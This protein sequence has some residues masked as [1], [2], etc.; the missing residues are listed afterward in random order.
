MD[1]LRTTK[2]AAEALGVD[3]ST[4]SRMVADGRLDCAFQAPGDTGVRFF[5]P[6]AIEAARDKVEPR[7]KRDGAAA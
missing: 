1:H 4:V 6:E 5:T 3:V 2:Q 7:P